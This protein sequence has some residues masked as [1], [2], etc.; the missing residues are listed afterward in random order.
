[1]AFCAVELYCDASLMVATVCVAGQERKQH[2][3]A[4]TQKI[5]HTHTHTH[6][7]IYTHTHTHDDDNNQKKI[8][9]N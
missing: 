4:Q 5:I 9:L 2:T 3:T 6:I 8:G 7:Y 1:M